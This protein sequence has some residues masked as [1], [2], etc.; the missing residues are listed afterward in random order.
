[1]DPWGPIELKVPRHSKYEGHSET[2]NREG[3]SGTH[4]D[5]VY[6]PWSP[7]AVFLGSEENGSELQGIVARKTSFQFVGASNAEKYLPARRGRNGNKK[8]G[9]QRA[10]IVCP[11]WFQAN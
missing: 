5:W 3:P 1:V 7:Q 11:R 10:E 4:G 2:K 8:E 9:G 6:A